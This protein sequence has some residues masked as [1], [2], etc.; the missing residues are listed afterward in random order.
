MQ[1]VNLTDELSF[2]RIVHGMWR[3]ADWRFSTEEIL[4]LIEHGMDRG[5][6]TY[7]HADIYGSYTCEEIFWERTFIKA[8]FTR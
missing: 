6:T 7:D 4:S 1:R 5:V 8:I 2:S 3:L